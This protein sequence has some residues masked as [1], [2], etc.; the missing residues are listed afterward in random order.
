LDYIK[1]FPF[2]ET[3]PEDNYTYLTTQGFEE[4]HD[5]CWISVQHHL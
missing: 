5:K 1:L 4:K 2:T 3:F